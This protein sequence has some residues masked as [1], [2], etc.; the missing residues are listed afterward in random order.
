MQAQTPSVRSVQLIICNN[1]LS[2]S[3]SIHIGLNS[4]SGVFNEA[5][6][7]LDDILSNV[8]MVSE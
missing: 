5:G 7:N 6:R 3:L 4:V 2:L 8:R 1:T